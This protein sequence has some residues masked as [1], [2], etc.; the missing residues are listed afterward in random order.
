MKNHLGDDYR[1]LV[2]LILDLFSE[3]TQKVVAYYDTEGKSD[4]CACEEVFSPLC[5]Y[6]RRKRNSDLWKLCEDDHR[7]R[8]AEHYFSDQKYKDGDIC[9]LGLWNLSRPIYVNDK[10]YGT[11][12]TGQRLLSNETKY[13]KSIKQFCTRVNELVDE[14]LI[15]T[16]E[17]EKLT[18]LFYKS[19]KINDF[20][21]D[22]I[23]KLINIESNIVELI[24][25]MESQINDRMSKF[26]LIRHELHQPN[27]FAKGLLLESIRNGRSLLKRIVCDREFR[28]EIQDIL[29]DIEYC[30]KQ[31][32][33][34]SNIIENISG[35]FSGN[36]LSINL[37]RNNIIQIINKAIAIHKDPAKEKT[38]SIQPIQ[39][40]NFPYLDI[41]CDESLLLRAFINV[42]QN[43][44][45]YS[46][47]GSEN[48]S[49]QSQFQKRY[50]TTKLCDVDKK[51]QI[52]VSNYGTGIL[53]HELAS[54]I[55]WKDGERGELSSDRDRIGSGLGMP[56]IKKIIEA[57]G[58]SVDIYSE[59]K[60]KDMIN[61]PYLTTIKITLNYYVDTK[62]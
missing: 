54:G 4:W 49:N 46:Y 47:S 6:L 10:F 1:T 59:A 25:H 18:S 14:G 12:I 43:A 41:E 62:R 11:L 57:H 8:T 5:Y 45:K 3:A 60:S 50:V 51:V 28:L 32:S 42:Y 23:G 52:T 22:L 13:N 39:I 58:G 56:Q 44:V 36:E 31:L 27:Y 35:S 20:D 48:H 17:K 24:E 37:R 16:E 38:V 55:L 34:F 21:L 26:D 33:I 40:S 9:H 2:Q 53:P 19:E 15:S 30:S 61:G 29:D 7:R